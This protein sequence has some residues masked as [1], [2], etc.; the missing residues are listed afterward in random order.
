MVPAV[1]IAAC[2]CRGAAHLPCTGVLRTEVPLRNCARDDKRAHLQSR[3]TI[4][5]REEAGVRA[6]VC[7]GASS[8]VSSPRLNTDAQ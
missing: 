4:T 7:C 2:L 8:A 1:G 3:R 6:E 5:D